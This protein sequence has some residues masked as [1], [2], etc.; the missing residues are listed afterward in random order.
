MNKHSPY[1]E[2]RKTKMY[3]ECAECGLSMEVYY[4]HPRTYR[5]LGFAHDAFVEE[6]NKINE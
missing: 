4:R 1:I 3:F 2:T 5:A 6:T